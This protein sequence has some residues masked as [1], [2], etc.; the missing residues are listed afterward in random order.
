MSVFEEIFDQLIKFLQLNFS[1]LSTLNFSENGREKLCPGGLSIC[2]VKF[3][4]ALFCK[5]A[6]RNADDVPSQLC[7]LCSQFLAMIQRN[8]IIHANC[9]SNF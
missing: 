5:S 2:G 1:S 6:L 9:Q 4:L 7:A 3:R 8:V